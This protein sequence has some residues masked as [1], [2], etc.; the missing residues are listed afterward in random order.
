MLPT[1]T[2]ELTLYIIL[3]RQSQFSAFVT[4]IRIARGSNRSIDGAG[5]APRA[6]RRALFCGLMSIGGLFFLD[7][8]I[9]LW[10]V[11]T[12]FALG[13]G[14]GLVVLLRPARDV[15]SLIRAVKS[16]ELSRLEPLLR[17][18]RDD[19]LKGDASTQG[20]LTDLLAYQDRLESTPE[21]P[22][23]SSTLLRFGLYLLIPIGSMIGGAL[24]ERVVNLVLD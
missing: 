5:E 1:E 3:R 21:W 7:S 4:F 17:Q 16:E 6:R 10:A 24:V 11:P 20:R 2:L 14:I 8:G 23:D 22:F 19:S 13:L 15:Q 9:G 12:F 18:A